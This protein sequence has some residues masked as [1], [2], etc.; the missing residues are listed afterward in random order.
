MKNILDI[1]FDYSFKRKLLDFDA[2]EKIIRLYKN[3]YNIEIVKSLT[4]YDRFEILFGRYSYA[5]YLES[6]IN[7]YYRRLLTC[8]KDNEHK[9]ELESDFTLSIFE[10][11]FRDNLF[12][13]KI[14]C[15]ELE[16]AIQTQK[17]QKEPITLEDKL[18]KYECDYLDHMGEYVLNPSKYNKETDEYDANIIETILYYIFESYD[19]KIYKSNYDISLLERLADIDS[20]TKIYKMCDEIKN[21]IPNLYQLMN[22]LLLERKIRNYDNSFIS[23]TVEFFKNLNRERI[24]YFH[25]YI[26]MSLD[27]RLRL[28]M[29]INPSESLEIHRILKH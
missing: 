23:P 12:I 4:F 10:K 2:I 27:E 18:I 20:M 7:V 26:D 21:R 1:V 9:S 29:P 3:E 17:S 28:G 15:H 5:S 13:L 19:Y 25:D 14:I 16:H 6:E 22:K 11:Y 24:F 8:I